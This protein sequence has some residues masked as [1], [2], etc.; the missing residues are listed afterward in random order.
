MENHGKHPILDLFPQEK[1][2]KWPPP[3]PKRMVIVTDAVHFLDWFGWNP[4]NILLDTTST[5]HPKA[6]YIYYR[7]IACIYNI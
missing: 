6:N 3:A 4:H 5:K 2:K 7:K 1:G